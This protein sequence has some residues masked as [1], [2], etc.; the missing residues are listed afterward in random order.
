[1]LLLMPVVATLRQLPRN[2]LDLDKIAEAAGGASPVAALTEMGGS[3]RTLVETVR[4]VPDV[5]GYR[6]GGSYADAALRVVPNVGLSKAE[7]DWTDPASLPP[8]HWITYMVAPWAYASFGGLGFSAIAEPYLNFGV[9]GVAGYFLLLGGALGWLDRALT[10][11]PSRRFLA[12]TAVVFMPLLVTVRNDF[13]N[14]LRPAAWGA[15]V[16]LMVEHVHGK[17]RAVRR[18]IASGASGTSRP[19][20]RAPRMVARPAR[21]ARPLTA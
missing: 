9:L 16:V 14:F 8:N 6:L 5:T 19:S 3:L 1:M 21:G 7:H 4:L 11:R 10:R 12:I 17:R 2:G 20:A 15:A 18:S 13:H